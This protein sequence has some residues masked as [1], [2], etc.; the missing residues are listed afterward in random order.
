MLAKWTALQFYN[1]SAH[2]CYSIWSQNE[3]TYWWIDM[4]IRSLKPV[5][6][7]RDW[8]WLKQVWRFDLS[9]PWLMQHSRTARQAYWMHKLRTSQSQGSVPCCVHCWEL[10]KR[11][12]GL[13]V[14]PHGLL[15]KN[16]CQAWHTALWLAGG[17]GHEIQVRV[18]Q[19]SPWIWWNAMRQAVT[20]I[21]LRNGRHY[22]ALNGSAC[23]TLTWPTGAITHTDKKLFCMPKLKL[24][25]L[26]HTF[27][28]QHHP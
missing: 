9:K 27:H 25:R 8:K 1:A 3:K 28:T 15:W 14:S 6:Q 26:K 24:Q 22:F 5:R 20:L 16:W 19:A 21:W 11:L 17:C 7:L 4:D 12:W 23:K 13:E 18:L 10:M 2:L